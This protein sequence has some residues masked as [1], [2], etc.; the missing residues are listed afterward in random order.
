MMSKKS[1]IG[2]RLALVCLMCVGLAAA[3][4]ALSAE[5]TARQR[6][7]AAKFKDAVIRAKV[8]LKMR[9]TYEG[10]SHEE[11]Q[12]TETTATVIDPSGLAVASLTSVDPAYAL[13]AM[14]QGT[15]DTK[16]EAEV[17]DLKMRFPDGKEVPAKVVLRDKDLDL[18]VIRPA[19][20]LTGPVPAIDLSNS[21]KPEVLDEVLILDRLGEVANQVAAVSLDRIE[22][23]VDKPRTFYIAGLF[24]KI[25]GTPGCPV[26]SSDGKM[27]GVVVI[28]MLPRSGASSRKDRVLPMILPAADVLEVVKQVP[29][30]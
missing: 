13:Q 30:Q 20:K 18:A 5:A 9:G 27:I 10:E 29:P 21:A 1:S 17:T 3:C 15:E 8:V 16:Y 23:V 19:E 25:T 6:E 4:P 24:S 2:W 28:R 14:S 12:T 7:V 11:E 26:L 22:A